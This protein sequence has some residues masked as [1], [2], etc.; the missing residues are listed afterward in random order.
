MSSSILKVTA[1]MLLQ[2]AGAGV[3]A[4][5]VPAGRLQSTATVEELVGADSARYFAK[6]IATDTPIEWDL[7]VPGNY[8]PDKPAGLLVYVS[9]SDSGAIPYRWKSVMEEH[10]LI[11]VAANE[12]G[13]SVDG[14]LRIAYAVLAPTMA[15]K[16]YRIDSSRVYVSGLSGGGRVASIVAPEY[17]HIFNG[18]IYNCGVNFWGSREPKR[19]ERVQANRYVFVTGDQ[20]FNR[21]ETKRVYRAYKKAGVAN[22]MLMDI[23]GMGHEN[24]SGSNFARAIAFLDG[25]D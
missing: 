14:G 17:A 2:L 18:A 21:G 1:L 23:A 7:F 11:W 22:A 4:Q 9:P 10:N 8:D 3:L 20:D 24:P 12:S 15:R 6:V 25:Q 13:N 19:I 16:T 5:D